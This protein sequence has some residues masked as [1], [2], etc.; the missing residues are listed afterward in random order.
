MKGL[1][2]EASARGLGSCAKLVGKMELPSPAALDAGLTTPLTTDPIVALD[3]LRR[4]GLDPRLVQVF[5]KWLERRP[6]ELGLFAWDVLSG[7]L[8]PRSEELLLARLRKAA[9]A[10][11]DVLPG[12]GRGFVDTG[13]LTAQ[14][15]V[16]RVAI[17]AFQEMEE[18]E[19]FDV[20]RFAGLA[21]LEINVAVSEPGDADLARALTAARQMARYFD[22]AHLPTLATFYYNYLWKRAGLREAAADYVEAML[23]ANAHGHYPDRD[24][25]VVQGSVEELELLGYMVGRFSVQNGQ[26]GFAR[27]DFR[28][29]PNPIDYRK[30][31]PA[32]LAKTFQ[33]SHLVLAELMLDT[34]ETPV[35]LEVIN[36]VVKLNPAWRY[37][38]RVRL[39]LLARSAPPRSQQPLQLLD[40][41]LATFGNE[42]WV[43]DEM[44]R[45]SPTETDWLDGFNERLVREVTAL[46]HNRVAWEALGLVQLLSE[47]RPAWLDEIAERAAEQ[48]RL[49]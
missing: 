44:N 2:S 33:R 24:Q 6:L 31:K 7:S 25:L 14:E 3:Q 18:K 22:L 12:A 1:A 21:A 46:P 43:W 48:C 28:N 26:P 35:P 49:G 13:R 5:Y 37:A 36:E 20:V 39:A 30:G 11:T 42:R 8:L 34:D 40:S 4:R 10:V 47:D 32:E 16:E 38:G 9:H 45:Y 27:D 17:P 19:Q 29:A 15:L 23:D 41:F